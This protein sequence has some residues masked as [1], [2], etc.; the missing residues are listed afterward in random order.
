MAIE[1][2]LYDAWGVTVKVK[3]KGPAGQYWIGAGVRIA[4][5]PGGGSIG[6][7]MLVVN[8]DLDWAEYSEDVQG[9]FLSFGTL[10][11]GDNMDTLKAI[12]KE[13]QQFDIGGQGMILADTDRDVYKVKMDPVLP[14]T[15]FK[16][17]SLQALWS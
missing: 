7:K 8:D 17:E 2:G 4:G 11:N 15:Q 14:G 9:I 13:G 1:K 10:K 5:V 3:H 12:F 16:S 6:L